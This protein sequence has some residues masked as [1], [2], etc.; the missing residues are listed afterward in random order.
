MSEL[1]CFFIAVDREVK[2]RKV[3]GKHLLTAGKDTLA[4]QFSLCGMVNLLSLRNGQKGTRFSSRCG[5]LG[6]S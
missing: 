1:L 6:V 5:H 2:S 4:T 3:E